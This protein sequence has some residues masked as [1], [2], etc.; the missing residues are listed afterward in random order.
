MTAPTPAPPSWWK[1]LIEIAAELLLV[2]HQ[3]ALLCLAY[4]TVHDQLLLAGSS[5]GQAT[6]L[7]NLIIAGLG[8]GSFFICE[9]LRRAI[10]RGLTVPGFWRTLWRGERPMLQDGDPT[11]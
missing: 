10:R 3:I 1:R 5:P 7:A 2:A 6:N 11:G 4:P 8:A 9:A